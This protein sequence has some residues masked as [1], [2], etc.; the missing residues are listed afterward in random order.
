MTMMGIKKLCCLLLA[1]MLALSALSCAVAEAAEPEGAR[2]LRLGRS[3]YSVTV[4]EA[5][6]PGEITEEDFADDLVGYYRRGDEGLDFDIYQFP[7]D[8]PDEALNRYVLE[9]ALEFD[10][11]VEVRPNERVNDIDVAWY[12]AI[13]SFDGA[14]YQTWNVLLDDGDS[15]VE[16]VFWLEDEADDAEA[17]AIVDS[18]ETVELARVQLGDSP[19]SLM[20]P[21]DYVSGGIRLEDEDGDYMDYYCSDSVGLDFDVYQ[22]GK[23]GLPEALSEYA[24]QEAS[25]YAADDSLATDLEI[26]GVPA[27][28]YRAVEEDEGVEYETV[29]YI[30]DAG[31]QYVEVVFW[32]DSF[33]AGAEA[34]GII[35]SLADERAARTDGDGAPNDAAQAFL[36]QGVVPV[37]WEIT[38]EHPMIDTDEARALYQQIKAEDYPTMEEL[39]ANPVVQQLDALAGYYKALY[40]NTA[41]IDTPERE[42]LREELKDWFLSQGSA[43]TE[44]VDE[45]GKH[46]YVYDGPLSRDFRMELVLGLPASGKSTRVADPDSEA[47][48]AFI[49]DVDMIKEQIPE[50]KE[51]HG[52]GADAIHFE[53]MNIFAEALQEFLSGEMKGT[54]A[55]LP[56]VITDLDELMENYIRPFE[57]AGYSVKVKFR[58][59]LPN[60]AAARVVMREL[61]GGQ[62]INSKVAFEFSVGVDDV[63]EM[64]KEMTNPQGEPYVDEEEALAPAA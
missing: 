14:E 41:E 36:E 52:A 28:C 33:I 64:L 9:E 22:F 43:R 34:D 29:T 13:E 53:G 7:K 40:G 18:L 24:R 37:T 11:V 44:S 4:D 49:L 50:Y 51:S 5:F 35:H 54:N 63:Y 58:E 46:R 12:R 60:E 59:A 10:T 42:Q 61:A 1:L 48:G 32:L 30:L 26:N 6:A 23:D 55:I 17:R 45:N 62:L 47:M 21:D 25:E 31:D 27:A 15:F 8:A 19:F 38:P 56:I 2:R 3:L 57:E 39:V 16:I 20:L